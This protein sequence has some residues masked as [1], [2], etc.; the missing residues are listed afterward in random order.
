MKSN[1]V[2]AD[3]GIKGVDFYYVPSQQTKSESGFTTLLREN[4]SFVRIQVSNDDS[5][6]IIRGKN[7]NKTMFEQ[8]VDYFM[9]QYTSGNLSI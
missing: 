8:V 3:F 7:K 4:S 9:N 2:P 1:K 6:I 5:K